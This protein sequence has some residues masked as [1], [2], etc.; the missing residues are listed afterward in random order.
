MPSKGSLVDSVQPSKKF[1]EFEDRSIEI[2]QEE[3]ENKRKN[4]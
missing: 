4:P 1:S 3:I 2:V